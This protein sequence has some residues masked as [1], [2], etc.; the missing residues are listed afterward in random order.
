MK[1]IFLL[2]LVAILCFSLL[3]CRREIPA[4]QCAFEIDFDLESG[5]YQRGKSMGIRVNVTNASD[6]DYIVRENYGVQAEFYTVVDGKEYRVA[7]DHLVALPTADGRNSFEKARVY[8]PGEICTTKILFFRIANDAPGGTY[9]FRADYRGHVVT[10]ENVFTLSPLMDETPLQERA[11]AFHYTSDAAVP[12]RGEPWQLET[13]V[14]NIAETPYIYFGR[15]HDFTATP[16]L[17]TLID[18][19]KRIIEPQPYALTTDLEAW[20]TI[21]VGEKDVFAFT[22]VLPA[23][24]PAGDYH[25]TL[26]CAEQEVTYERIFTLDAP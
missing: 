6:R 26:S 11:F 17:Y 15:N 1:R 19:E 16:T 8:A 18:G 23:D 25:L 3:S 21:A 2:C 7:K 14:T 22:Y 4:E 12:K 9:H 5:K 13:S 10:I 20:H 24:A